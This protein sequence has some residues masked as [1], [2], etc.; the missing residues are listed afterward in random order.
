MYTKEL[1]LGK[2]LKLTGFLL[3]SITILA[4]IIPSPGKPLP[5]IGSL[6]VWM[7]LTL[8]E[9]PHL[10]WCS[11]IAMALS[12]SQ[13]L[14]VIYTLMLSLLKA[15]LFSMLVK[16]MEKNKINNIR[17]EFDCLMVIPF[18]NVPSSNC[19]WIA[20]SLSLTR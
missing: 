11:E 2:F 3:L 18:L 6:L 12:S 19:Y 7:L 15:W 8:M 20:L 10:E 16:E 4:L 14:K 17:V 5:K 13:L 9:K 1:S